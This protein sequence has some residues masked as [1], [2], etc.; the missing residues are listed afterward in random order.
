MFAPGI[1]V[2][3]EDF[4]ITPPHLDLRARSDFQKSRF[5][6]A[7][8]RRKKIAQEKQNHGA[9]AARE[10]SEK[11]VFFRKHFPTICTLSIRRIGE[12]MIFLGKK[13]LFCV[14]RVG[15]IEFTFGRLYVR[16]SLRDRHYTNPTRKRGRS[17]QRPSL[18]RRVSMASQV[19]RDRPTQSTI[20]VPAAYCNVHVYKIQCIIG[21]RTDFSLRFNPCLD[22]KIRAAGLS[23]R[24]ALGPISR[25]L[26]GNGGW[27]ASGPRRRAGEKSLFWENPCVFA[28]IR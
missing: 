9:N 8:V 16:R 4:A 25:N 21:H 7:Q 19:R 3:S 5:L 23:A 12:I 14:F 10:T 2:F 27:T 6:P 18:A 24:K 28:R 26:P 22:R 20:S 1:D 17:D 13:P 11:P 15:H